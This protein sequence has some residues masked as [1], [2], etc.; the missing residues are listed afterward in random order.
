M[1]GKTGLRILATTLICA[2]AF[3]IFK[4]G[5]TPETSRLPR[6][7]AAKVQPD[8]ATLS[9]A[10]APQPSAAAA[11]LSP[12]ATVATP[13]AALPAASAA[14]AVANVAPDVRIPRIANPGA[15]APGAAPDA[16]EPIR[17]D[18]FKDAERIVTQATPVNAAGEFQRVTILQTPMKYSFVRVEE[19]VRQ[20][21]H[22]RE[23]RV[24]KQI[25]AVADHVLVKVRPGLAE[26]AVA[27]LAREHGGRV[28]K[29]LAA[30]DTYLIEVTAPKAGSL[31]EAIA[32]LSA[33][34]TLVAYAEPDYIVHALTTPNDPS[35]S[36]L[37]GMNNTGQTGGAADAD[38]DAPEAWAITTGSP[39]VVVGVID[40]GIDYNHP[41]LA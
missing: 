24:V 30:P 36:Q 23:E 7:V 3:F 15:P 32:A 28:R 6:A 27:E 11:T 29:K 5:A 33:D 19:T 13:R 40:T 35:F 22:T 31:P 38:I 37:W 2:A 8:S 14:A 17:F 25:A 26:E 10:P 18:I 1:N 41:D 20:E 21:G 9:A 16:D 12:T 39:A 34:K 4:H